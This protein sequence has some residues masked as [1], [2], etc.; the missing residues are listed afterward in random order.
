MWGM[1]GCG[2]L[3]LFFKLGIWGGIDCKIFVFYFIGLE[4]FEYGELLLVVVV[5]FLGRY[6]LLFLELLCVFF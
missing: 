4:E 6:F 2:F 5:K 1:V 3:M